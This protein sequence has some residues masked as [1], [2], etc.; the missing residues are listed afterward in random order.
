[1]PKEIYLLKV[2]M[3]MTEGLVSEW[4]IADGDQ[5][6]K[7]DMLYALET[8][9]VNMDVDAEYDG[10][11]KHL[12]PVGQ[13]M[14]PGD[15]VG[16]IFEAGEEI[17]ADIGAVPAA[18]NS[19][20]PVEIAP[21]PKVQPA[22]VQS[23]ANNASDGRVKSSP[24]ARRL[25]EELGVDYT[26]L[27]G[28]GPGGRIVE[29]DVQ[30]ASAG[31]APAAAVP[32]NIKASPLAKRLA[33]QKGV[34]LALVIGTG[35]GGRIVESDIE[36]AAAAPSA[37]P[38]SGP[39][40]GETIPLRGMRK[41]IAQR[42]YS[43]IQGS[44]QLTMDMEASMDDT[45]RLRE[46]LIEEWQNEQI[47]PTYTD[48]VVKAVA[49]ALK[50]HPQMNSQF[51][52]TEITLLTDINV[53]IAVAVEDGLVVP[54]V[55]NAAD[56]SVKEIAIESGRLASLAR[57]GALGLDDYAGGT[58]TVS[59]LGMYGVDSFTPII[60]EPQAGILGV[61]RIYDGMEWEGDRPVKSKKMNLSLT[62]D[63][64]VLDGAPAAEFLKEVCA[65]LANPFRLL[66]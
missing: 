9:K 61:N 39:S 29:I 16:F 7:G 34:N 31:G 35:P 49:K 63:H 47:R 15:V 48:L 28:T 1:M 53:G 12:V 65:L 55:R 60:N 10:T 14:E 20:A 8:E 26:I 66:V 4:Y 6:K 21:E 30:A 56:L 43:S 24:A 52:E 64:R 54:V 46:S 19:T 45:V 27:T 37:A 51:G 40:A 50:S 36:A 11:V 44:A 33:E 17:P 57:D 2:G 25:A 22:A 32:S 41:T 23:V 59:A 3:T 38:V 62:W 42:M 13:A 58:F 5:V 18:G